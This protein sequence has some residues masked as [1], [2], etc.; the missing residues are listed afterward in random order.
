MPL[1]IGATIG[2]D[3]TIIGSP[4]KSDRKEHDRRVQ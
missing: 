2:A 1:V 4:G 3:V